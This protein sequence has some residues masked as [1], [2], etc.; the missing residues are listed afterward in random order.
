MSEPAEK[1]YGVLKDFCPRKLLSSQAS[2][3][4]VGNSGGRCKPPNEIQ[5]RS[6][7]ETW[8]LMSPTP[9]EITFQDS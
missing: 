8:K 5:G 4:T 6:S 2:E 7:K 3:I 1:T 9:Q